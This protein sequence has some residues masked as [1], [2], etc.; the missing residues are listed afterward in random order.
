LGGIDRGLFEVELLFLCYPGG[1]VEATGTSVSISRD[2]KPTPPEYNF[3][4]LQLHK[5]AWYHRYVYLKRLTAP[6]LGRLK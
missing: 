1:T 6:E 4:A 3:R 2:S 5:L